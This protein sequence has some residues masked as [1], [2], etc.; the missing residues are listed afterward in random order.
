MNSNPYTETN[1]P[2]TFSHNR[3]K[4]EWKEHLLIDPEPGEDDM[5]KDGFI[6]DFV[7]GL[8][9]VSTS[10]L[11]SIWA[12]IATISSVLK[13]DAWL[14]WYPS[15]L[16]PNMYIILAAPPGILR[17]TTVIDFADSIIQKMPSYIQN[18][19][20]QLKKQV[21]M[22]RGE[23][24]P[25]ALHSK[26]APEEIKY[27]DPTTGETVKIDRGSQ[28]SI[29]A[30]ELSTVINKAKYN[31]GIIEKLTSL[32]DGRITGDERETKSEGL[33]RLRNIFVT[34]LGALTPDNLTSSIPEIA[35]GGGFLS[36][37]VMVY[38]SKPTRFYPIPKKI[39]SAPEADELAKRLAWIAENS[40]GEYHLTE[41]AYEAYEAWYRTYTD[42][43]MKAT[44]EEQLKR[45]RMDNLLLRLS[46]IIRAQR[47]EIGNDIHLEDFDCAL[48]LL[49]STYTHNQ[50]AF[51]T[52]SMSETSRTWYNL[53]ERIMI[54]MEKVRSRRRPAFIS[55]MSKWGNS[56]TL[57]MALQQL[58][59]MGC[60]EV[61]NKQGQ[62]TNRVLGNHT[63]TYHFIKKLDTSLFSDI[64]GP[65]QPN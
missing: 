45:A 27:R 54:Y 65:K 37:C 28:L 22:L 21:N 63:E 46:L 17:K 49:T 42:G 47:Y 44:K 26:L 7:L 25:Q 55:V 19:V 53:L 15:P 43:F 16:V 41:D 9:G 20:M 14:G 32:F 29:F 23:I 62:H 24:T 48:K 2:E 59:D 13:R 56:R 57:T 18:P 35:L 30:S 1:P 36:R 38:Q 60:I 8:K 52:I 3:S 61:E 34:L 64:G 40:Y 58:A 50:E 10:S 4:H 6:S 33:I 12:A 51:E 11:M 5:P 31:E 39:H